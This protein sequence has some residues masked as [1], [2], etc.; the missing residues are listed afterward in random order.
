MWHAESL[1]TRRVVTVGTA[2]A[3]GA[4]LLGMEACDLEKPVPVHMGEVQHSVLDT[5]IAEPEVMGFAD[6][7]TGT[8]K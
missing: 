7:Q 2:V 8:V 4:A 3:I 1:D 6:R 5:E